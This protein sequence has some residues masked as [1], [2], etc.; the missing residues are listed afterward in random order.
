[1]AYHN[2]TWSTLW[3]FFPKNIFLTQ[4]K[5]QSNWWT[6]FFHRYVSWTL[7]Q[8]WARWGALACNSSLFHAN[9]KPVKKNLF[10]AFLNFFTSFFGEINFH[11]KTKGFQDLKIG[12]NKQRPN[13][14]WVSLGI[15][16]IECIRAQNYF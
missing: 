4:C 11:A 7:L 10:R 3:V 9:I 14:R 2:S 1:M 8:R 13:L 16:A 5:L 12:K 6:E 15:R